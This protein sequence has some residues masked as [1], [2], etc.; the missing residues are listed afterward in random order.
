MICCPRKR[1]CRFRSLPLTGAPSTRLALLNSVETVLRHK[2]DN[3][4]KSKTIRA[5]LL[6]REL[7]FAI[8]NR[9]V[10]FLPPSPL[11]SFVFFCFF[12]VASRWRLVSFLHEVRGRDAALDYLT[13]DWLGVVYF[14]YSYLLRL[15]RS[16][17][18]KLRQAHHGH[19]PG[20][21]ERGCSMM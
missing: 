7:S 6:L 1:R 9:L 14:D 11:F 3:R 10:S 8:L 16:K 13:G 20:T 12:G 21:R 18:Q 19:K 5:F 4:I 17:A 15:R 2:H